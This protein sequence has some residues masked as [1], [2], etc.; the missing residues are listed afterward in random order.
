MSSMR[1]AFILLLS[2]LACG[3]CTQQQTQ[4]FF[5]NINE[6]GGLPQTLKNLR[7]PTQAKKSKSA[8]A[9]QRRY[10]APARCTMTRSCSST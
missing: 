9:S 6:S 5:R 1:F 8:T 2:A 4:A 7:E 10:S 3:G